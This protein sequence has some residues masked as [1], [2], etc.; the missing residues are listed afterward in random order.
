L[1]SLGG[2]RE[3]PALTRFDHLVLFGRKPFRAD[4]ALTLI[5]ETATSR[6]FEVRRAIVFPV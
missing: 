1:L 5:A 4:E 3:A 6:L 2:A